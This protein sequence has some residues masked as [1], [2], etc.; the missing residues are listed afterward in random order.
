MKF[1]YDF[2]FQIYPYSFPFFQKYYYH[3]IYSPFFHHL[4]GLIII[5]LPRKIVG[6][7]FQRFKSKTMSK[8]GRQMIKIRAFEEKGKE[9]GKG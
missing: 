4:L 5:F 2:K 6:T 3:P 7:K 1:L 9:G 8:K